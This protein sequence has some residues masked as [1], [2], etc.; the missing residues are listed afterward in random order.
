M[1]NVEYIQ[2]IYW[3]GINCVQRRKECIENAVEVR[4]S[5]GNTSYSTYGMYPPDM[6]IYILMGSKKYGHLT[7]REK[8]IDNK[9][10]FNSEGKV[11]LLET[12]SPNTELDYGP[13]HPELCAFFEYGDKTVDIVTCRRTSNDI[14]QVARCEFYDDGRLARYLEGSL[15]PIMQYMDGIP[16]YS[17]VMYHETVYDYV[18]CDVFVDYNRFYK[19]YRRESPSELS[20]TRYLCRDGNIKEI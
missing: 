7:K 3:K 2:K 15:G 18:G 8:G 1:D 6:N 19:S 13:D 4:M 10:Y 11:T 5:R 12:Y 14:A 16:E 20:T 9:Y 17:D